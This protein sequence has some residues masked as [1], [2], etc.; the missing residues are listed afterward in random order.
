MKK[1]H[2]TSD[3]LDLYRELIIDHAHSPRNYRSL[4]DATN[5]S[6]GINPLCGDKLYLYIKINSKKIIEDISFEGTGCAVSM[7]SASLLT[8]SIKNLSI[9][10]ANDYFESV[11]SF[12]LDKNND[13]NLNKKINL[14]KLKALEGVKQ[15]PMRIKCATLAW[16]ALHAA[17][18]KT[19]FSVTTE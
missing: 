16:H 10:E 8:E 3:I 18:N 4:V 7:A 14:S 1:D 15:Y 5:S 19:S 13:S 2:V 6:E 9:S 12:M 11:I 17:I